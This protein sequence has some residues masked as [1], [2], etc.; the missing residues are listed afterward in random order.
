MI[1]RFLNWGDHGKLKSGK[2]KGRCQPPLL[3]ALLSL[4]HFGIPV[5]GIPYDW[6]IVTVYFNTYVKHLTLRAQNLTNLY[7]CTAWL[8]NPPT[9]HLLKLWHLTYRWHRK[10]FF[11]NWTSSAWIEV[12]VHVFEKMFTGSILL[13]S[14]SFSLTHYFTAHLFFSL[15]CTDHEP[16]TGYTL[17]YSVSHSII[18]LL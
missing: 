7:I 17:L 10:W 8:S 4:P 6:S 12:N 5:P 14:C 3:L 15:I 1:D 2:I 11:R 16:G 13:S 18:I 9:L